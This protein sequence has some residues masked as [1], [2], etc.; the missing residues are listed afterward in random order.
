MQQN[1]VVGISFFAHHG[2]TD[3][4]ESHAVSPSGTGQFEP[5]GYSVHFRSLVDYECRAE[6]VGR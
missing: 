6:Q 1:L 3:L 2:S 4:T 5:F